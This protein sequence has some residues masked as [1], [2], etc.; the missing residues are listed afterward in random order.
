MTETRSTTHMHPAFRPDEFDRRASSFGKGASSFFW[1]FGRQVAGLARPQA[2]E[3]VLDV[4]AGT[5]AVAVPLG[6][7]GAHVLAVDLS[8]PMLAQLQARLCE[9]DVS[10][11]PVRC[12]A[13]ALPC[14]TESVHVLTCGFGLAFFPELT[15][16]LSEFRRV[17]RLDG[18]LVLTWWLYETHTP[19]VEAFQMRA[20]RSDEE[21][22]VWNHARSL[23]DPEQIRAMVRRAGFPETRVERLTADWRS[24]SVEEFWQEWTKGVAS[25]A[26][27]T[28]EE[29]PVLKARLAAVAAHWTQADGTLRYPLEA[30]AV[31]ASS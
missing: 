6:H 11:M 30:F 25:S 31:V 24:A 3:V 13:Q 16:A 7:T 4:A 2:G 10:I 19:F 17:L 28:V 12:T 27:L 20:E 22:R 21:R 23:A 5:G 15:T 14:P 18:R 29:E 1:D 9:E 8:G 26:P